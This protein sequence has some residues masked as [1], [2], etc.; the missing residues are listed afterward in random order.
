MVL[1]HYRI[2]W[3]INFIYSTIINYNYVNTLILL[4]LMNTFVTT[5]DGSST[6][7]SNNFNENY[8]SSHGALQESQYVFIEKGL[9]YFPV[10]VRLK[11]FEL[12]F[13]TGLNALLSLKAVTSQEIDY[14]SV[15]KFPLSQHE[16]F[17]F[18][19]TLSDSDKII[20]D[21][22]ISAKWNTAT[23]INSKFNLT[24]Y[25]VCI[26]KFNIGSNYNIIYFDAFSPRKQ[27]EL[28]QPYLLEKMYTALSAKGILVTY[29][30]KGE[31]KRTLREVGFSVETLPG[32]PGKREM[33]RA[34]K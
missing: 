33:I 16:H 19:Q 25:H 7:Y 29:C 10:N 18:S 22:L 30:A 5:S 28:W 17:L 3:N 27:P 6:F 13:G 20:Y 2:K 4:L 21:K 1:Y 11:V 23:S 24:K 12:G 9:N 14:H 34:I 8:H 15:E 32:P 26:E 31:V